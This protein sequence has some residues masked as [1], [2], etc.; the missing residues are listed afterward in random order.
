LPHFQLI[1][2]TRV[3]QIIWVSMFLL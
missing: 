2:E 3:I 1:K